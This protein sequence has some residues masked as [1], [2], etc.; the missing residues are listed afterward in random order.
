MQKS[1]LISEKKLILILTLVQFID[2]LDFMIVL[3]L[4]PDYAVSLNVNQS[5]LG[6]SAVFYTIAAAISGLISSR[7]IDLFERKKV[8][9][10]ALLGLVTTNLICGFVT[11]YEQL[12]ACRF[13][14]GIFGGPTTAV[15]FAIIADLVPPEKRGKIIGKIMTAFSLAATI[16]VPVCLELARFYSW[17]SAFF[18]VAGCG[19]V[20]LFLI[21]IALPKIR[22]HLDAPG[23]NVK[24]SFNKLI[25]NNNY[26][27]AFV[28]ASVGYMAIFMIIPYISAYLQFNMS[29]DRSYIGKLYFIGGIA[30]FI[31]V[32]LIGNIIDNKSP[33]Y[34]SFISILPIFCFLLFSYIQPIKY[35][36]L[37]PVLYICLMIGISIRNVANSTLMSNIPSIKERAGFMAF[38][39]MFQHIASAMGSYLSSIILFQ[40]ETKSPLINME[41]VALIALI[42]FILSPFIMRILE[43]R[44]YK[45]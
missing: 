18:A 16:G 7:Y 25:K 27:L 1:K 19:Y 12:L 20:V 41:Y 29:F 24:L 31:T 22:I 2:I 13:F 9:L 38:L 8:L 45:Q 26:I 21:L 40:E 34:A 4:G 43:K 5:K 14:A 15:C 28:C 35:L 44:I 30:S 3:P 36:L 39:S 32:Q 6:L 37:I 42:F 10:W 23:E 17:Q 33:S 11:S